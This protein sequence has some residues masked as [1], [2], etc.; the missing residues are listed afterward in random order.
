MRPKDMTPTDIPARAAGG[1]SRRRFLGG[2]VTVGAGAALGGLAAGTVGTAAAGV[3][4]PDPGDGP[5]GDA[6]LHSV[7]SG[8]PWPDSVVIWTRVTPVPQATPGSGLG[9]PTRVRWEVSTDPGFAAVAAGGE[10]TTGPE[11]D[12]T[13]KVNVTG[14][15]PATTYHYRFTVLDGPAAGAVSRTGR[16][17]TTPAEDTAPEHLRFGVCSCSNYEAGYFRAYREL[18]DRDDVEF[19]LH[20]G[21]YTYEYAT[22]EYGAAYSTTVR[23]AEPAHRTTTLDDYRVRQGHYRRDPDLADLHAAKPMICIW[24]DHEFFDNAWRDGA[25]GDSEYGG[26]A[27]YAAV[28][29]AATRAYYEWMPVRAGE[30]FGTDDSRHLYRHLRYGTLAEII[31]PDLRTYRDIE[32]SLFNSAAEGRTMMGQNQ[33]DWFANVMATSSTTWQLVG[34]S[35]MFSPMTLPHSLDP[36]LHD[37]LVDTVDL[38]AEGFAL[39]PDQW[40]GYMAERQRVVDLIMDSRT[41]PDRRDMNVVF[42]TGDIH[43][44][45]ASDVPAKAGEYRLGRDRTVA[46]AEFVVPSVTAASAFDSIAPAPAAAPAVREVLKV[47]ERLLTEA[48]PWYKYVDL[49]RHGTMVVD[50]DATRTQVDWY[51]GEVLGRTEPLTYT[52]SW[53]TTAGDPGA[54]PAGGQLD[55]SRAVYSA[56]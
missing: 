55:R 28:R 7:A 42:L 14:L 36:R 11:R 47:G 43:S 18:A 53:R 12:H 27:E 31:L 34:N 17:R 6:F 19:V 41:S 50:V 16:T 2:A 23:R 13:V 33:F 10:L 38:P 3:A 44:S 25:T 4:A 9:E 21:D 15:S 35:V 22:G 5:G 49:S 24:D 56:G 8:D 54:R 26:P 39:N 46:A 1:V 48:D 52:T 45:W 51:H 30:G 32:A 40:D 37:W 20:L 29:Q